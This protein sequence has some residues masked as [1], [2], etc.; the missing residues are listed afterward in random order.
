MGDQVF[1]KTQFGACRGCGTPRGHQ[2][3]KFRELVESGLTIDVALERL[4]VGTMCCMNLFQSPDFFG[5]LGPGRLQLQYRNALEVRSQKLQELQALI[6]NFKGMTLEDLDNPEVMELNQLGLW[7]GRTLGDPSGVTDSQEVLVWGGKISEPLH[8]R[9]EQMIE[10]QDLP[11]WLTLKLDDLSNQ[12]EPLE[13]T[14]EDLV[15]NEASFVRRN[16]QRAQRRYNLEITSGQ[17]LDQEFEEARQQLSAQKV[18]DQVL[19]TRPL[20]PQRLF[21]ALEDRLIQNL[22]PEDPEDLD[23]EV[24]QTQRKLELIRTNYR[25]IASR[26]QG[27]VPGEKFQPLVERIS[28][29]S[30]GQLS[31]EFLSKADRFLE[32]IEVLEFPIR[33]N[34]ALA[35]LRR[36][37]E[38]REDLIN[39]SSASLVQVVESMGNTFQQGQNRIQTD[40]VGSENTTLII[41]PPSGVRSVRQRVKL[42]E[43][44]MDP[45]SKS[46][47]KT[48]AAEIRSS[49]KL[50]QN[51]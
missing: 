32:L 36:L 6:Q 43:M 2:I 1:L 37:Y 51:F 20:R 21:Q 10:I 33:N 4:G 38:L 16:I 12:L 45:V 3:L 48:S 39:D 27:I 14:L 50:S 40:L 34:F 11:E 47:G 31:E 35:D 7:M 18:S 49:M 17:E 42:T 29:I 8:R 28:L 5:K 9:V 30:Q 15:P 26:V 13:L 23:V 25:D 44:G 19:W 24:E 22:N 46:L 41:P